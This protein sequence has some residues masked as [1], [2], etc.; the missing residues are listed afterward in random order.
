METFTR[1][2]ARIVHFITT[3]QLD[4]FVSRNKKVFEELAKA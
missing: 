2:L 1:F 3:R 4:Y